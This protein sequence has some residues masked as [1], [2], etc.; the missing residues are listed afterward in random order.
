VPDDAELIMR[1]HPVRGEDVSVLSK[2]FGG[3]E[4]AL[5]QIAQLVDERRG[6]VLRRARYD[7]EKA[8]NGMVINL[9]NVVSVRVSMKTA[10]RPANTCRATDSAGNATGCPGRCRLLRR[11]AATWQFVETRDSRSRVSS[12]VPSVG[13]A[14]VHMVSISGPSRIR[15]SPNSDPLASARATAG[16]NT[17]SRVSR[18]RGDRPSAVGQG[19]GSGFEPGMGGKP[20]PH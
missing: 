10:P 12:S 5:E 15:L 8:E 14:S 11:R 18:M 2:D 1:F 6:L 9:A 4:E 3:E 16:C 19:G 17:R 20:K 13:V 7:R